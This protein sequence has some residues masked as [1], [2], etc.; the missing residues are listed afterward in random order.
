MK[1]LAKNKRAYFDYEI[2]DTFEGGLVLSGQEVKSAKT[3]GAQ[4]TGSY[5]RII[6]GEAFLLNAYIKPYKHASHLENYD[7]NRT[8]KLLLHKLEIRK[9]ENRINEK[10]LTLLPLELYTKKGRIKVKLGLGRAR[11][12]TD[13]RELIKKREVERKIKHATKNALRKPLR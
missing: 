2:S 8:R 10:G 4:L 12:R 11:K 6:N 1:L 7:P 5:A 13:K 9:L 3:G